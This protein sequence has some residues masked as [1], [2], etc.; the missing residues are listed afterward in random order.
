[1]SVKSAKSVL[2]RL[3]GTYVLQNPMLAAVFG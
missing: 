3:A 1:M 2:M